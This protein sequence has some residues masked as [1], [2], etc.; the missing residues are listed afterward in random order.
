M[1]R[2]VLIVLVVYSTLVVLMLAVPLATTIS[3]ERVQ[4]FGENRLA[5]ASYFADLADRDAESRDVDLQD[6]VTR[7]HDLYG[8]AVLVVG[9]DGQPRASA[10]RGA[11]RTQIADDV[12]RA[13]RNQRSP[14]PRTVTPWSPDHVVVAVP[15]GTGTQVDGAV[16]LTASTSAA[17]AD[18]TRSWLLIAAGALAV[19]AVASA[20]AIAMARWTVR[21]LT[22][23]SDRVDRLA[24]SVRDHS[25]AGV[26]DAASTTTSGDHAGPTEVRRL[27]TAFDAMA[28]DVDM[29]TESQ[30]RLVADSAHA[31]RNPLAA[32]RIRLDALGMRVPESSQAAHQK[33]TAE[34]DRLERTV[35]DLLS[36]A[37]AETRP[38][39]DP[40]PADVS[41]VVADR[42]DFWSA[43]AEQAGMT[44]TVVEAPPT[45]LARIPA[46]D[47]AQVLD[48]A[49]GNATAYAGADTSIEVGVRVVADDVVVWV[50]DD[51]RGVPADD[52]PRLTDRFVR[53]GNTSGQG[54]GLGLAIAAAL[55]ERVGGHFEVG[56]G[57][58]GGLRVEMTV[59]RP[60]PAPEPS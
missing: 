43:A 38:D 7:Y 52:V 4:R 41:A 25:P 45:A 27:A 6:A 13:L 55:V 1:R 47:L 20:I 10:G 30:R 48:V 23:L 17:V 2:R 28:R 22:A 15:V 24:T 19:L 33:A 11:S 26:T 59:P 37:A 40:E 49:L 8:E 50:D 60:A 9:R 58:R 12:A 54:S 34:V 53:A 44:A 31:L 36:L 18:V 39:G 42:V 57:S 29:A 46:G 21:P 5:A 3:R 32:L 51:G 14:L 16:V 56:A 35:A